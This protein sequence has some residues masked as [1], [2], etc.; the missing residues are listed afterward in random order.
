MIRLIK[1]QVS[2]NVEA[3]A[4]QISSHQHP[5]S[6]TLASHG[7]TPHNKNQKSV[8]LSQSERGNVNYW[9]SLYMRSQCI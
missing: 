3:I 1:K 4:K 6:P 8:T 2:Q 7:Y 9:L 5:N